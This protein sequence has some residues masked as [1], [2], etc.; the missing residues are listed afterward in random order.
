MSKKRYQM[1][2]TYRGERYYY[3][4]YASKIQEALE[5]TRKTFQGCEIHGWAIVEEK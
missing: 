1:D 4:T 5:D 3:Y 2:I